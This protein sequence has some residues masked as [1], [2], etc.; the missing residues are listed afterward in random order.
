MTGTYSNLIVM[1]TFSKAFGLASVR[2]GMAFS[3][4]AIIQYFNKLKP[5][6]NISTIN[7]KAVMRRLEKADEYMN[8]IIKIKKERERLSSNLKKIKMIEKVYPSDS[9]FLLVKVKN[10]TRIYDLLAEKSIIVR[11]RSSIIDNCLRI[12]VGTPAENNKLVNAL[13]SISI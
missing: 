13:N 10:A 1:Q 5:P 11:N 9:N 6:Y 2:V 3:N 8:Q 12:T 7:Q 4:P